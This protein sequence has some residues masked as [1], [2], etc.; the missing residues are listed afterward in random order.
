V[1]STDY[2]VL[3]GGVAGL[4]IGREVARTGRSVI[5]VER[6]ATDGGLART[7]RRDG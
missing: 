2:V 5:V 6:S 7:F 4:T 1:T 3:D